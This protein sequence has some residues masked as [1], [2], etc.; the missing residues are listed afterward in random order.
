M[1]NYDERVLEL[2]IEVLDDG[3]VELK[4]GEVDCYD[5][6]VL[7]HP[8]HLDVLAGLTGFVRAAEVARACER[9]QDR[10]NL[11]IGLV[12]AHTQPSDPLR[13][14][15]HFLAGTRQPKQLHGATNLVA[16]GD[17]LAHPRRDLCDSG[18]STTPNQLDLLGNDPTIK[19][20]HQ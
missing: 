17:A 6:S 18:S 8:C 9:L 2:D 10:L 11:L 12:E 15:A 5:I 1:S 3:G 13:A 14:A 7:L 16:D 19:E 20:N 4:Q